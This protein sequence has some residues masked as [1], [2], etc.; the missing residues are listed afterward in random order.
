M[1]VEELVADGVPMLDVR[2]VLGGD[3]G[4][5]TLPPPVQGLPDR[6]HPLAFAHCHRHR[7]QRPLQR[8]DA[9][10][11]RGGRI[12]GAEGPNG[13]QSG[14]SPHRQARQVGQAVDEVVVA[15]YEWEGHEAGDEVLVAWEGVPVEAPVGEAG[16]GE[17]VL[18]QG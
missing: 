4:L 6:Y 14:C 16:D 12:I 1:R 5:A 9:A 17:V 2:Q 8:L 10:V 18:H 15:S 11:I 3:T 7:R 13:Q